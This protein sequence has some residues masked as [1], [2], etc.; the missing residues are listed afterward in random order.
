MGTLAISKPG[1]AER[2]AIEAARDLTEWGHAGIEKARRVVR[3]RAAVDREVSQ[4]PGL[5]PRHDGPLPAHQWE[6]AVRELE[7]AIRLHP[8]VT[9]PLLATLVALL[10]KPLDSE[11][12][13]LKLRRA[14][15]RA[16]DEQA[17]LDR[18]NVGR[19][20]PAPA[21]FTQ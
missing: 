9:P 8:E 19:P 13:R 5:T 17:E 20:V 12:R 7:R 16:P 4:V 21:T 6:Q 10:A 15:R 18:L 14:R 1:A 11:E 2:E 3:A